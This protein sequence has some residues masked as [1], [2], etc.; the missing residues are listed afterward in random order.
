M[1]PFLLTV[2]LQVLSWLICPLCYGLLFSISRVLKAHWPAMCFFEV[3]PER[4]YGF[5]NE[6]NRGC[7]K[8]GSSRGYARGD[9]NGRTEFVAGNYIA[10]IPF[11]RALQPNITLLPLLTRARTKAIT[12]I[13]D[14][15][16]QLLTQ[17][18]RTKQNNN[19]TIPIDLCTR[20]LKLLLL[21][22]PLCYGLLFSISMVFKYHW[23][24]MCYFEVYPGCGFQ[25]KEDMD[26][27]MRGTED[28]ETMEAAEAM[29]V[30]IS[31]GGLSLASS[32]NFFEEIKQ[33]V[34][35][36]M[37]NMDT[38]SLKGIINAFLQQKRYVLVFNDVWDIHV[39]QCFRYVFPIGN[40]GSR[41]V[42]TTRN[43]DLASIA[44][45]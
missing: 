20:P 32:N 4:G 7:G 43:A 2:C 37:D 9:F 19:Q 38:N 45:A 30:V 42:L 15:K 28:V 31:M 33:P 41:V 10:V 26:S 5:R 44:S 27:G 23:L 36:G 16:Q 39:W 13:N 21:I 35:Q 8:Y 6:G 29:L 1:C 40:C 14:T 24:A 11:L 25:Q 34:L 18:A 3:Y 22:C 17:K 12:R